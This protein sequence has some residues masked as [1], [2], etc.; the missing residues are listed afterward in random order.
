MK[1]DD[2]ILTK[3][4]DC[5]ALSDEFC[6]MVRINQF[7]SLGEIVKMP[8]SKL[9]KLPYFKYRVLNELLTILNCYGLMDMVNDS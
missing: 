3:P 8:V 5:F 6:E 9:L 7:H 4:L 1:R 2:S